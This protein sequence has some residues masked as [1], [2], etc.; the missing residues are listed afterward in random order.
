MGS[1]SWRARAEPFGNSVSV[2]ASLPTMLSWFISDQEVP[3][4]AAPWDADLNDVMHESLV[5]HL[6]PKEKATSTRYHRPSWVT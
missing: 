3:T 1:S 2:P 6:P 4:S 5:F